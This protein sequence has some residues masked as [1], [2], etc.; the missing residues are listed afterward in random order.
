[1]VRTSGPSDQAFVQRSGTKSRKLTLHCPHKH[2]APKSSPRFAAALAL[3]LCLEEI[4]EHAGDRIEVCAPWPNPRTR[5]ITAS[6]QNRPNPGRYPDC[7]N[8]R[9]TADELSSTAGA[10][11]LST[12]LRESSL[13]TARAL[14]K[15]AGCAHCAA[16]AFILPPRLRKRSAA[17]DRRDVAKSDG[18]VAARFAFAATVTSGGAQ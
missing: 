7:R 6:D 12:G 3:K 16:K 11:A 2:S 10:W 4:E 8:L 1:M 9:S 17:A 15:A 14:M 5:E 13:K 18:E